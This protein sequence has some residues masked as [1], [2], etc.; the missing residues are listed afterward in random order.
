MN[1]SRKE[2]FRQSLLSI[3]ETVGS[4]AGVL[5][6]PSAVEAGE[7]VEQNFIPA[8][9]EDLVAIAHNEHCLAK[10]CGCFSCVERCELDAIKLIPGVGIRIN[11][12]LCNGCGAC[13]YVCPVTP[14]AVRM[15]DRTAIQTSSVNQ[16]E[17]PPQK[18]E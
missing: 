10:N 11:P 6:A 3:G 2:F 9:R 8:A 18:G 15:Q 7:K 1:I 17:L 13:E 14:K 4:I 16:A 12:H 5:K